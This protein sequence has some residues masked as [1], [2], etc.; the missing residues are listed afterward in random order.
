MRNVQERNKNISDL[1]TNML[2]M[3]FIFLASIP[4]VLIMI[5][6]DSPNLLTGPGEWCLYFAHFGIQWVVSILF[7]TTFYARNPGL[8]TDVGKWFKDTFCQTN[9]LWWL[10][11]G[12]HLD[13]TRREFQKI[14]KSDHIALQDISYKEDREEMWI[15]SH[16][17]CGADSIII[18]RVNFFAME[19][20]QNVWGR[21]T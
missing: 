18:N 6:F 13:K 3:G 21:L 16:I 4:T 7:P 1:C 19:S 10:R 12:G 17:F 11:C 20:W 15:N 2:N 14:E 9:V 5:Y 8:R